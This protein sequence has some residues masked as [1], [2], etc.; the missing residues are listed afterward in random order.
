MAKQKSIEYWL[1]WIGFYASLVL[2]PVSMLTW[3]SEEPPFILSLSW[4][5]L[6]LTLWDIV[7]TS[8]V[9]KEVD[10]DDG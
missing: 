6:T 10:D 7:K 1:A 9:D 4:L 8:R 2:W 3:A 5:A